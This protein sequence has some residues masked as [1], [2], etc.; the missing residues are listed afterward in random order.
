MYYVNGKAR[1]GLKIATFR[2]KTL[3]FFQVIRLNWQVKIELRRVQGIDVARIFDWGGPNHKSHAM[4]SSEIFKK[5]AF[6]GTK[7]SQNGRSEVVVCCHLTRILV[8]EEGKN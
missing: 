4:T 1:C 6:C 2:T 7:I 3:H 8:K 5:G